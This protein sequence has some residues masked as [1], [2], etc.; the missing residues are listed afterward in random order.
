MNIN[1]E[2]CSGDSRGEMGPSQMIIIHIVK[3]HQMHIAGSDIQQSFRAV[4]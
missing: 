3:T 4:V 1:P 2:N